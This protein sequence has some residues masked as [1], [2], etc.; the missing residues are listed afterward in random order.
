MIIHKRGQDVCTATISR[1]Y[2]T[3]D[4][5]SPLALNFTISTMHSNP[6]LKSSLVLNNNEYGNMIKNNFILAHGGSSS[7]TAVRSVCSESV[8]NVEAIYMIT[9]RS[10]AHAIS[11]Q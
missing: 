11:L 4:K 6:L 10:T 5:P 1:I 8:M 3:I 9:R 7:F 2:R